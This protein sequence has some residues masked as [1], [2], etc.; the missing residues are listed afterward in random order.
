MIFGAIPGHKPLCVETFQV[1]YVHKHDWNKTENSKL[2]KTGNAK[3][4]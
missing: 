3:L 4:A 1:P 2:E